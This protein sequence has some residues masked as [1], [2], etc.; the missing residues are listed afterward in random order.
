M[1]KLTLLAAAC[2]L[3]AGFGAAHAQVSGDVVKI[4]VLNDQSGPYADLGG[5]GGVMAAQMAA[6]DFG[7]KVLGKPIQIVG[8]DHQNNPDIA[9]NIVSMARYG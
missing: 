7:G 9:S 4:G 8:A 6:D 3:T 2:V 1:K 5:K